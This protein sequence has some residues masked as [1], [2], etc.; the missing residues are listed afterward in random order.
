[1]RF[2]NYK[3]LF[4]KLAPNLGSVMFALAGLGGATMPSLVGTVST[5]FGGLKA[6][7]YLPLAGCA[8]MLVLY[9]GTTRSQK[10]ESN[11]KHEEM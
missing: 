6:G 4:G 8:T 3:L 2:E 5:R 10:A 1:M 11:L 7:L 9:V